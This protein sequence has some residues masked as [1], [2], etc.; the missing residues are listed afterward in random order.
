MSNNQKVPFPVSLQQVIGNSTDDSLQ[1]LGQAYPCHVTAVNGAIVTVNFDL[2]APNANYPPVTCATIGSKY[3]RVPIQVGDKGVCMPANA[4]LGGVTG[5]G[6]GLAPVSL[7]SNLGAL[8]FVPL[9][10]VNWDSIDPTAT[11]IV[12]ATAQSIATFADSG[13]TLQYGSSEVILNASGATLQDGGNQVV[14]SSSGVAI[15]G[16][17]TINGAP[18]L[19]HVHKLVQ[20]G[21]SDSGPVGP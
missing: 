8:V 19:L 1:S 11:V 7:P 14:V 20:T 4:R 13:T 21:T 15:N 17:L 2:N 16:T 10:N 18:Y 9:G 12:S 5:L 6:K 3:V